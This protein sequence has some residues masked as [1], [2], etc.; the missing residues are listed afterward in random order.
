MNTLQI[1]LSYD[2]Y[3]ILK[4][5]SVENKVSMSKALKDTF[6]EKLEDEHDLKTFDKA[7]AEYLKNPIT[8]TTEEILKHLDN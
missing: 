2:E 5:F 1:H 4:K 7:Y 6:F 3:K 8:Y